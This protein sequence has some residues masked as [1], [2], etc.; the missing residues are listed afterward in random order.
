MFKKWV[1]TIFDHRISLRERMFRIVT[2]ICMIA[3]IIILPMGRT[4]INLLILA[5]SL[6]S[7]SY[8][9]KFSIRKNCINGGATAISVLLLLLFP[10]SFFNCSQS[11]FSKRPR[12]SSV[13]VSPWAFDHSSM[14]RASASVKERAS[15]R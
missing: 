4:L 7:I 10:I 13:R 5:A 8:I 11:S 3:L 14:I 6:V 2:A 9:V 1:E 15:T 12:N